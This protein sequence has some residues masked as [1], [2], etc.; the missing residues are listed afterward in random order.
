MEFPY[1]PSSGVSRIVGKAGVSEYLDRIAGRFTLDKTELLHLHSAQHEDVFI[2]EFLGFGHGMTRGTP[3]SQ[4]YISVIELEDGLIQ[5]YRDYWNPLAWQ[6]LAEEE[7][8][9]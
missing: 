3:Y 8:S 7:R 4:R 6:E 5:R 2:I 1:A 9:T